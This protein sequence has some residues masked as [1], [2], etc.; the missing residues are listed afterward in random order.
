[1]NVMLLPGWLC[2]CANVILWALHKEINS[3]AT[4]QGN[5]FCYFYMIG[6]SNGRFSVSI[7]D[8]KQMTSQEL[9]DE[10]A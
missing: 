4:Q 9:H 7:D 3:R 2:Y 6:Q 5:M 1:M 10:H 8:K